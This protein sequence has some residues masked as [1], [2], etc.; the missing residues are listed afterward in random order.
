MPRTEPRACPAGLHQ[1]GPH[2]KTYRGCP[3]CQ[4]EVDLARIV[5]WVAALDG[6]LDPAAVIGAVD[7][8]AP[9]ELG[10][11]A[12]V[13]LL[14]AD[15]GVLAAGRSSAPNVV[16][17][18]ISELVTA[19]ATRVTPPRCARC[20]QAK[21]R[22]ESLLADGARVCNACYREL[23]RVPCAG[24]GGVK[25]HGRRDAEGVLC[26]NCARRAP[27]ALETCDRC[28]QSG[29]VAVR[30]DG[31]VVCTGCYR[32]PTRPC[33]NC[34]QVAPVMS[35]RSGTPLCPRC[36]RRPFRTCG[37]CGQLGP[38]RRR[39][40]GGD[41]ELCDS[42]AKPPVATCIHCGKDRPCRFVSAGRPVCWACSPRRLLCCAHCQR[43]RP[44]TVHWPEGPVC[45]G[46]YGAALR[47][48]GSCAGCGQERRLVS[49]PGRQ[50]RLCCDCAGLAPGPTCGRC[51]VE[52][53]PYEGDRCAR[54]VLADRAAHLLAG[55]DGAIP[56]P[57]VPVYE[58]IVA[59][60]SALNA[61]RWLRKGASAALLAD[62]AAGVIPL[63]HDGLD[64][65]PRRMAVG[66]LREMLVANGALP[67]RN[68]SLASLERW[69]SDVVD[70]VEDPAH[71]RLLNAYATWRVL[72]DTRRRVDRT[73]TLTTSTRWA[74]DRVRAAIAFLG[75]LAGQGRR[76][77]DCRQADVDRW[78]VE[79]PRARYEVRD[80]LRWA[81]ARKVVAPLS[82]PPKR[83]NIGT[84]LTDHDR[85]Q[86]TRRLLHDDDLDLVDRVAG[87]FV[88]LYAQL[89]GRITRMT[90]D[91]VTRNDEG[92]T[93][94]FGRDPV[95]VPEP[96]ADLVLSLIA[97]RTRR[98]GIGAP[99]T[100][101][102]WLFP[103]HLPGRPL[104]SNWLGQRLNRLGVNTRA[105]RRAAL[106]QLAAEVPA[107]VLAD[108]LGIA[109]G[110]AV[111]WVAAAG[112]NWARYAAD[113]ART[114]DMPTA[115]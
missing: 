96:L 111:S 18:F 78:L 63:T 91:D 57:L 70:A 5:G 3:A 15:P 25:P 104:S 82:V 50:A 33:G 110:T 86:L 80:F 75:W 84:A 81:V 11:R 53:K 92:V 114:R 76:I 9:S 56:A 24:C 6:T 103:G 62:V 108:L 30:L 35:R 32:A 10:R 99:T 112:G 4:R 26:G 42:C 20:G 105:S 74:T 12:L 67:P 94:R 68:E 19:G 43:D 65:L 52:D 49:P 17:R 44:A 87:S 69:V 89:P 38:I 23:H 51:G 55:P 73:G 27:G 14:E 2:L 90:L 115:T 40:T 21:R 107:P 54:C 64:A 95:A 71:G 60:R 47:R 79:G 58:S 16:C 77:G 45:G 93:V 109:P 59:A 1:L 37:R 102:R 48:R 61:V 7:A 31:E 29:V 41:P 46:C 39:A 34:G 22:L 36:Y 97:D 13:R 8:A 113:R 98:G 100:P 85:W 88:L 66:Y 28:H 83:W 72:R 106:L 101:T